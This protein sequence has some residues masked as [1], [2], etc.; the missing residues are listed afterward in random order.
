MKTYLYFCVPAE[1]QNE[2]LLMAQKEPLVSNAHKPYI[3]QYDIVVV[4]E[5]EKNQIDLLQN[6]L[7]FLGRATY[8]WQD[9]T[10]PR[11]YWYALALAIVI[12]S[13]LLGYLFFF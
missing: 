8:S 3:G 5:G 10:I 4:A 6:R 2:F 1:K 9:D 7:T 12:I 13:I 11:K